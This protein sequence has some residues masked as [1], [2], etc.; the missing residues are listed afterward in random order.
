MPSDDE[1][2]IFVSFEKLVG[3]GDGPR[4]PGI[5]ESALGKVCVGPLER[6]ANRFQTDSV[7]VELIRVYFDAYGRAGAAPRKYLADAIDLRELLRE[8]G[9]GRVVNLRR[10]NIF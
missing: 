8:D 5:R 2:L 1:R 6:L 3:I 10:G 7:A 4:L 9:I